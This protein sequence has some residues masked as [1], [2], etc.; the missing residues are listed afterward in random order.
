MPPPSD[1]RQVPIRLGQATY[2]AVE[3][4]PRARLSCGLRLTRP[5]PPRQCLPDQSE[6]SIAP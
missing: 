4:V 5:N 6:D 1:T 2:P 3:K